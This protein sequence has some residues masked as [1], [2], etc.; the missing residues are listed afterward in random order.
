MCWRHALVV[1]IMPASLLYTNPRYLSSTS[2]ALF[3]S[4]GKPCYCGGQSF[5]DRRV[6]TGYLWL[7][8]KFLASPG[9]MYMPCS[10]MLRITTASSINPNS[11]NPSVFSPS[12]PE[13]LRTLPA[14]RDAPPSEYSS[15]PDTTHPTRLSEPHSPPKSHRSAGEGRCLRPRTTGRGRRDAGGR[16][17]HAGSITFPQRP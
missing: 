8:Y 15:F 12:P 1:C 11:Q 2:R 5:S 13:P 6:G 7:E 17:W 3:M 14:H 9:Y 4:Y 10:T 16:G